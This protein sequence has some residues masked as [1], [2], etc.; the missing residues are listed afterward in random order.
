MYKPQIFSKKVVLNDLSKNQ[1]EKFENKNSNF[2]NTPFFIKGKIPVILSV[3]H[4][5]E[6]L[7]N[8][9]Y[10]RAELLTKSLAIY[11]HKVTKCYVCLNTDKNIDP[12]YNEN[13]IYKTTLSKYIGENKITFLI[14]IHGAKKEREF[15]IEVGTAHNKNVNNLTIFYDLLVKLANKN[16]INNVQKDV[17]FS[18]SFE[19]TVSSFINKNSGLP[20]IQLEINQK[21]RDI[22]DIAKFQQ[23]IIFLQEYIHSINIM[24]NEYELFDVFVAKETIDIK[25]INKIEFHNDDITKNGYHKNGFIDIHNL[26]GHKKEGIIFDNANLTKGEINITHRLFAKLCSKNN[27]LLLKKQPYLNIKYLKPRIEEIKD[28]YIG[29]S[30]DL[31]Q[32]YKD[33]ELVEIFNPIRNIHAVFYFKQYKSHYETDNTVWLSFFQ[34]KLLDLELPTNLTSKNIDMI[35]SIINKND[36][37]FFIRYY[38][39]NNLSNEYTVQKISDVDL[40]KLKRIYKNVQNNLLIKPVKFIDK[41]IEQS[42]LLN[43]FIGKKEMQLRVVR[44][45]EIEDSSDI[46]KVTRN[47]LKILGIEE[48]DRIVVSYKGKS[49]RVRVLA[50]ENNEYQKLI[51]INNLDAEE[52]MDLIV[53]MPIRVRKQLGIDSLNQTVFLERDMKYLF[54]KNLYAQL[55]AVIGLFIAIFR[56]LS[57]NLLFNIILF[58]VITPIVI[59]AIL[60]KERGKV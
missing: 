38:S 16:G 12:N 26:E 15:D 47:N 7:R 59:Y 37:D 60:S 19:N 5:M 57:N 33:Y 23:L 36:F 50:I 30:K 6:H 35:K 51:K 22:N 1:I 54:S 42:P 34:R 39:K 18:A 45:N 52:D 43:F 4:C 31:F 25:P 55:I 28:Q 48:T 29:I 40:M 17:L 8:G 14:D 13:D 32:Q 24:S 58:V 49:L 46:I 3:P 2:L 41:R 10:K 53:C 21:F 56:I 27:I 11:L 9:E 20:C 44:G